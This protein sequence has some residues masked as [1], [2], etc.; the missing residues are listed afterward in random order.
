MSCT[1]CT[2]CGVEGAVT[3]PANIDPM[4]TA[5]ENRLRE[6]REQAGLTRAEVAAALGVGEPTVARWELRR[7]HIPDQRKIHLAKLLD[8]TVDDLMA[9]WPE[10]E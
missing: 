4:A 5:P 8:T 1:L 6:L 10:P 2:I 3:K 9:G 7:T